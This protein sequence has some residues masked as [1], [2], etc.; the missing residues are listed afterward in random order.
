MIV[1]NIHV[2][3]AIHHGQ[4]ISTC[5]WFISICTNPAGVQCPRPTLDKEG[6]ITSTTDVNSSVRDVAISAISEEGSSTELLISFKDSKDEF[7]A[8]E[9]SSAEFVKIT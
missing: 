2:T 9:V 4:C 7:N 3:I 5:K 8:L 6:S 1:R